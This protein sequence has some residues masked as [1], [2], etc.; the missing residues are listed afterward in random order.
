VVLFSDGFESNDFTGWT[1]TSGSPSVQGTQKHTGNY[2]ALLNAAGQACYKTF[3]DAST[4]YI[5]FYVRFSSLPSNDG[6]RNNICQVTTSGVSGVMMAGVTR[7]SGTARFSMRTLADWTETWY[8]GSTTS[9]AINTWYCVELYCK[10]ASGTSG[11]MK[12]YINGTQELAQTGINTANKG[13]VGRFDLQ[14]SQ[15]TGTW[16]PSQYMDCAVYDSAYIGPEAT[17]H[18]IT[19]SNDAHSSISPSGAVSV[20]DG[21]NQSFTFSASAG[22]HVDQ[23]LVDST[24]ASTTSPYNFTNVT[25]DHTIAVS[26]ART[27]YNITASHDANSTISPDDVTAVNEGDN[28]SYTFSAS[29]G[30]HISAVSVDGSPASTTSPYQF[31]NVTATHT[32]AVTSA[33]D[34]YTLTVNSTPITGIPFTVESV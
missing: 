7:V 13:N 5:R 17:N 21:G 15:V 34:T 11:E 20:S 29:A 1:G 33:V 25:A 2:A 28:Q 32:I 4:A 24:P 22:Y 16:A 18:T 31:T 23:L 9:I 12:L 14:L 8:D 30:Y 19:A 3:T 10:I 27:T 26:A 6:D